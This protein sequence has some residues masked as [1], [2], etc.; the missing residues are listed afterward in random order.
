MRADVNGSGGV[1]LLDLVLIAQAF[2]QQVP[3]ADARLNQ[4]GDSRISLLDIS[5]AASNYNRFVSACP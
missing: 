2:N 3:P 1:N 4:N 5:L